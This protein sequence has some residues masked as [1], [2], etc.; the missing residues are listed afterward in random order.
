MPVQDGGGHHKGA[1]ANAGNLLKIRGCDKA[2]K[3]A[4][5]TKMHSWARTPRIFGARGGFLLHKIRTLIQWDPE[6]W[7]GQDPD[8]LRAQVC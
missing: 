7:E 3:A 8:P 5:Y 1:R 2:H 6:A 4:N